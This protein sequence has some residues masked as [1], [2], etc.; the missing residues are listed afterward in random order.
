MALLAAR[1][2][3]M[4]CLACGAAVPALA[5]HTVEVATLVPLMACAVFFGVD[6][7]G[8]RR[9]T[10]PP[11]AAAVAAVRDLVPLAARR[12]MLHEVKL[13]TSFVRWI[14]ARPPHGVGKGDL[15]VRYAAGQTFVICTFLLVSVV[16]TAALAL[17]IPWPGVRAL[18]LVIDIWGVYFVIAL[19]AS[20]A[21]RP[22]VV[23]A[24]GSLRLRY[25]AL[26]EIAVP[27]ERIAR[28]RLERRFDRGGPAKLHPDASLDM[29]MGGQ[30]MVTVE[31]TEPTRFV[32]PL[33]KEAEARVL[34]FYADNP[35]AAVA[36]LNRRACPTQ[37][38]T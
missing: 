18:V 26:L 28:V 10:L 11:R 27:A 22:H 17:I 21:G 5:L 9:A 32:R 1:L 35:A 23:L 24:D 33:G 2:V 38:G 30:T 12:L 6:Y 36:A 34:R 15:A 14:C 20:C 4:L 8:H 37:A 25:G 29:G 13:F 7:R 19:Q 31:L 3:M 16:E